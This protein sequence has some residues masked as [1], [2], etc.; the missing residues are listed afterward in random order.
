VIRLM[1][2]KKIAAA[3]TVA[4]LES[5]ASVV[6]A[7]G[8]E[9]WPTKLTTIVV[10]Y[11]PGSGIDTTARFVADQLR[12]RTGQPFIVENRAGA[13][14]RIGATYVSKAKPDGHTAL[15][16]PASLV[17]Y[18]YLFKDVSFNPVTDFAPVTTITKVYY[19]MVVNPALVPVNSVSELSAYIKAHPGALA[20]GSGAAN[21][22][23]A[24]SLY[25][26]LAGLD[27]INVR[28]VGMPAAIN[29][30]LGGRIQF[31]F[32]DSTLALAQV[33]GGKI[34]ALG[35][36]AVN[37]M[38]TW[39]EVPTMVEAGLPGF[40]DF[41]SWMAVFFPANTPMAAREAFSKLLNSV[42]ASDEAQAHLPRFAM[43]PFPGSPQKTQEF[44][45]S[46]YA[47]YAGLIKA[48]GITPQ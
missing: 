37:R 43:D 20:Y 22:E 13:L 27:I 48:A 10:G 30:L 24:A 36:A 16:H 6:L 14:G 28:Y 2:F 17:T 8:S 5:V 44:I 34:R 21:P 45:A 31:T 3:F 47:R 29:D 40:E 11:P 12:Q 9:P 18:P 38:A 7:Q 33:R 35:V 4:A 23:I 1:T 39:P 32:A 19:V 26:K 15:L 46:E 25:K 42:M 41:S